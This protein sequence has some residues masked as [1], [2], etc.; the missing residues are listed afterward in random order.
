MY[1]KNI[2]FRTSMA[3][4]NFVAYFEFL[5]VHGFTFVPGV[6]GMTTTAIQS[7]YK[8]FVLCFL[9]LFALFVKDW[10]DDGLLWP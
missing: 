7:G 10:I 1:F 4:L 6:E 9:E 2:A 3:V 5:I 8:Y